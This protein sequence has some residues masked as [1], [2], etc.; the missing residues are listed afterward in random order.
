M[1]IEFRVDVCP[2]GQGF[3]VLTAPCCLQPAHVDKAALARSCAYSLNLAAGVVIAACSWRRAR[4]KVGL[5]LT[6]APVQK[7]T[8]EDEISR[9]ESKAKHV[10]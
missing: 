8:T 2:A 1:P 10:A 4:A 5:A 3:S 7:L 6:Q 9:Y